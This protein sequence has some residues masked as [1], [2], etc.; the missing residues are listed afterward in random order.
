MASEFIGHH[1]FGNSLSQSEAV[2]NV[3][4]LVKLAGP[5][6]VGL[7]LAPI[8]PVLGVAAAVGIG[9]TLMAQLSHRFTHEA[10]PPKLVQWAQKVGIAQP[11]K[12]HGNHHRVPWASNYT[13]VNG[14]LNPLLDKTHFWRKWENAIHKVTGA[15]PKTWKHP[16]HQRLR[17][18][19]DRR[20]GIPTAFRRR[21]TPI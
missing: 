6:L 18:G 10:R 14:A 17:S 21:D 19:Q 9:G 13:I 5:V 15:E 12:D 3:N 1:Y 4:P 2:E 11:K 20:A 8:H 16:R 7:A